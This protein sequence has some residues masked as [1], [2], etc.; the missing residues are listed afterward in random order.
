MHEI[1]VVM[2]SHNRRPLTLACLDSLF[3]QS[4]GTFGIGQVI[5]VDDASTDGTRVAVEQAFGSRVRCIIGTGNDYWAGGMRRGI[6]LCRA[7]YVLLLNDDVQLRPNAIDRLV[8]TA[9]SVGGPA[10]PVG[11]SGVV[12]TPSGRFYGGL[13]RTSRLNPLRLEP[14]GP[15]AVSRSIDSV[16]GN[17]L[18][19]SRSALEATGGLD[20][21][22][23]HKF[24]DYDW[25]LRARSRGVQL[26]QAPGAHGNC[27]EGPVYGLSYIGA[28]GIR[29]LDFGPKGLPPKEWLVYV[30]RHGGV[31]WP[32]VFVW[33]YVKGF[34]Q[35]L[36]GR[37]AERR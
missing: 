6:A 8:R 5:L 25:G 27:A 10:A 36:G 15:A 22:F 29:R 26:F 14:L 11:I 16:N 34:L 18:L 1:D 32:L 33:A 13:H 35:S 24:A 7:P 37:Q 30:R 9:D 31:L 20:R 12:V 23:R 28:D 2:A 19:V 21:T 4:A 17:L 3:S